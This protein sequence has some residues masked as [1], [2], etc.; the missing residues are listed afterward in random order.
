MKTLHYHRLKSQRGVATLFVAMILLI[1][2]TLVVL[3]T[4]KTVLKE[5]QV[6]ADDYRTSQAT[7]AAQAAMDKAVAY[8]SDGNMDHDISGAS[9]Y[10]EPDYT[11]PVINPVPTSPDPEQ[12]PRVGNCSIP[13]AIDGTA[14]P[15]YLGTA[16]YP[17]FAEALTAGG[18]T[19]I[20]MF[21]FVNTS[22]YDHDNDSTTAEIAN[23][24][25]CAAGNCLEEEP[26]NIGLIVAKGWSDDCTAVRT[27]TQCLGLIKIFPETGPTQP[28]VTHGS[29]GIGGNATFIN[30][31]TNSNV[32]TGG[33]LGSAGAAFA[34]Y[35]RPANED[36][37]DLT[38]EQ[39]NAGCPNPCDPGDPDNHVR[40]IS[41]TKA[42]FGV[43]II[44]NDPTLGNLTADEMFAIFFGEKTKDDIKALA[45]EKGQSYTDPADAE[46]K[47]GLIWLEGSGSAPD[48]GTVDEPAILLVNGD[49]TI[50]AGTIIRGVVYITGTLTVN[51]GPEIY[52]SI[53]SESGN[54]AG[55]GN[56]TIVYVP[57]GESE[58]EPPPDIPTIVPGSWRDW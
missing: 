44:G 4:S 18:Q 9:G 22:T 50:G 57:I 16:K 39:L 29:I 41:N 52:G 32:W 11:T 2:I 33:D 35:L 13:A 46:G 54:T 48:I 34:T 8:V 27:V 20:G 5:T 56:P 12:M 43:D 31:Y 30:R 42:G 1:S 15:D 36:L 19:T 53:I 3:F 6:V 47:S 38:K 40:L 17:A 51:G 37:T 23:P 26:L 21:Y 55:T 45:G 49:L 14:Y 25:E 24:C 7:A 10:G 58:D 28:F